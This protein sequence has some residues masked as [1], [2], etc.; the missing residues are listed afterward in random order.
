LSSP[1]L[2]KENKVDEYADQVLLPHE[3]SRS[4]PFVTTGDV[5]GDGQEDF[6]IGGAKD[7]TGSLYLQQNGK[8]VP[9]PIPAFDTDKKY[10]DMGAV[11][12]DAD[13]DGDMDL[14]VVSGGSEFEE[15]SPM[16]ND[17]LYLNDGKGNFTKATQALPVTVSSGSCVTVADIDGDGD[18]DIFRG[19]EIVPHKYPQAPLSYLFIN[20]KGTF[21]DR[22]ND[23]L[24]GL[25]RIGM[26]K[27]AVWVDLNADK[28]PELILAGEWMPIKVF[29]YSS[30]KLK[31]VSKQYGFE[32]TEGW[33]DK[34]VADDI[35][36][37]G[38]IDIVAGNIGE[39]YKFKASDKKPFEVWAKDFD[40]N[41]TND[42][43]LARHL[44]DN[45]IVP[46][47]GRECTS[48]QC[49]MIAQKFPTYLS[50]AESDLTGILGEAEMK[51]ALHYQAHLFSTVVFLN[52][53]GKF[54]P[55]RLPVEAQLS[56]V[57]GIIVKDFDGDGK[58][59]I[60]LAGNKFDV[61]VETTPADAS[62]GL[63]LKGLGNAD[64]RSMKPMES[65]F[66]APQNVKDIQ[67]IRLANGWGV[68]VTANND[69][70][71]FYSGK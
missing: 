23:M 55:K 7:Q 68:L 29:E 18:M 71:R 22:T 6:Y 46:I 14:Y 24:P 56:T 25:N 17:R 8:F 37:D 27:S 67:M 70:L 28:K 39:N 3:F 38:D 5:N 63:L 44:N 16:Y 42:I 69:R 65:G 47:R 33:W 43:F 52:E 45:T 32:K 36:G 11:F 58:K 66:F 1:F 15:G 49:P 61:E 59:D 9:K 2:H 26:V 4:G 54:T 48:Q 12:F 40:G 57:N 21:V 60:L 30:G 35:D 19:G 13:K 51:T 41:G 31:D 53:K 20:E 10:E 62:P 34:L 50:F 64:F